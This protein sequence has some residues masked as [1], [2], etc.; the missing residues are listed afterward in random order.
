VPFAFVSVIVAAQDTRTVVEPSLP[1]AAAF[2]FNGYDKGH[3]IAADLD[4]VQIA[5]EAAYAYSLNHAD[6]RLGPGATNLQLPSGKDST[7]EGKLAEGEP[8]ACVDKFVP[9][10]Q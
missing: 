8:A 5:D 10:P 7:I 6:I 2:S 3:R 9:F 1:P 4:G